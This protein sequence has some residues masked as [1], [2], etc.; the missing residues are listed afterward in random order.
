MK[1]SSEWDFGDNRELAGRL[2]Q[3]VVDGKKKA[4]TSIYYPGKRIPKPGE[5]AAILD[6][7]K[8]RFCVIQ[9]TNIEIKPFL[10]V[11]YDFIEKEGEGDKDVEEWRRKH[12]KFFGLKDDNVKVVCEEFQL[13]LRD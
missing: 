2:K 7:D 12:R 10:E 5:Y 3:L 4:T 8:K 6:S 9:Y 13:T 1:I 11:G